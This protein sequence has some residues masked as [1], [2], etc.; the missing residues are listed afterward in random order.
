MLY[1]APSRVIVAVFALPIA[2]FP[3]TPTALSVPI[4][5]KATVPAPELLIVNVPIALPAF[6]ILPVI[7]RL[8]AAV[9]IVKLSSSTNGHTIVASCLFL[10]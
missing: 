7:S 6:P 5:A 4:P 10:F 3:L 9:S 2:V 1:S 8:F